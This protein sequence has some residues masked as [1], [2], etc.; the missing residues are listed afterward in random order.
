M[1]IIRVLGI[2]TSF[3]L[4]HQAFAFG[5]LGDSD[6]LKKIFLCTTGNDLSSGSGISYVVNFRDGQVVKNSS[7]GNPQNPCK[8]EEGCQVMGARQTE[9][10]FDQ[11]K[12]VAYLNQYGPKPPPGRSQ[13]VS[14]VGQVSIYRST[15]KGTLKSSL[16]TNEKELSI[17]CKE[18]NEESN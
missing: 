16:L 4:T 12:Y 15:N 5:D 18:L 1:K 3:C 8:V 14:T 13:M 11:R 10:D 7:S 6:G 2:L 17:T 9:G